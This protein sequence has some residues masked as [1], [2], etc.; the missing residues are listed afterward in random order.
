MNRNL[1]IYLSIYLLRCCYIIKWNE[2]TVEW[3]YYTCLELTVSSHDLILSSGKKKKKRNNTLT[4]G[5]ITSD[6]IHAKIQEEIYTRYCHQNH[7]TLPFFFTSFPITGPWIIIFIVHK[8]FVSSSRR[9]LAKNL[10]WLCLYDNQDNDKN[11][12]LE[13]RTAKI[14]YV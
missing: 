7:P 4:A 12:L 1:S 9:H 11:K 5:K 2:Y 6:E 14:A 8:T 3:K 10:E 13:I